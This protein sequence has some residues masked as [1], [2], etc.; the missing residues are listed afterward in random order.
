MA[1]ENTSVKDFYRNRSIFITGATGFM[2]KVLVEKLMRSC[3]HIRNLYLLMRPKR[4]Q[5]VQ[6]RLQG[7]LNGPLFETLRRDSPDQLTKI[8]PVAGDIA[9]PEL[10]ISTQ[11]QNTLIRSVSIVFHSAATVNF[12][13]ALKLSVQINTLGTKRLVQLCNRMTNVEAFIHVSTAYCNCYRTD[14][15]EEIYPVEPEPDQVIALTE[16]RDDKMLEEL[17]PILIASR[18]NTYTFTKA[19]AERMLQQ[20]RGPLPVAIV[21][22]SIVMSSY[23]EPVAGWADNYNGPT[24]LILAAGKGVFSSIGIIVTLNVY[25]D[26]TTTSLPVDLIPG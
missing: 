10:G 18:P 9:V 25:F 3:P 5:N 20:E 6:E 7:I 17:T 21:R 22:P 1:G 16:W 26:R 2:G 8:I 19:L 23:R 14:V 15:V 4:G 11:D 24:G 13:E 12:D